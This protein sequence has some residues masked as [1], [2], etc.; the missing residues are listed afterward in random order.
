[1]PRNESQIHDS[2]AEQRGIVFGAPDKIGGFDRVSWNRTTPGM[3]QA[4]Q[5]ALDKAKDERPLQK[6][7]EAFPQALLTSLVRPHIAWVVPKPKLSIPGRS[8][9]EPDFIVCEWSSVG[10]NWYIVELESPLKSPLR[11]DGHTSGKL[12]YAIGQI[13]DYRS[14]L[15][16]HGHFLSESGWPKLH[17]KFKGVVVIGRRADPLRANFPNR[18]KQFEKFR[19]SGHVLRPSL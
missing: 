15:Q 12:N 8:P 19:H 5:E 2:P 16:Q 9:I 7:F 10:P 1:M 4:F 14:I 18:L 3:T 13:G 6:F 11:Q 17:G